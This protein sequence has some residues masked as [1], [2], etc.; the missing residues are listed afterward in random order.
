MSAGN[1]LDALDR[2]AGSGLSNREKAWLTGL[3]RRFPALS[4]RYEEDGDPALPGWLNDRRAVLAGPDAGEVAVRF[5]GFLDHLFGEQAKV[6]DEWF[7][8]S[9]PAAPDLEARKLLAIGASES[10]VLV[11]DVSGDDSMPY[12]AFRS[13]LLDASARVNSRRAFW[14]HDEM[15]SHMVAL[16]VDGEEHTAPIVDKDRIDRLA[17]VGARL[18]GADLSRARLEGL[19]LSGADLTLADLSNVSASGATFSGAI[20]TGASFEYADLDGANLSGAA[21]TRARMTKASLRGADLTGADLSGA[22][23]SPSNLDRA[24]AAGANLAGADLTASSAWEADLSGADLTGANLTDCSLP[25]ANLTGASLA[26]AVLSGASLNQARLDGVEWAGAA[27]SKVNLRA[28]SLVNADLSGADLSE[29]ELSEADL[30]GANLSNANLGGARLEGARLEGA[31]LEGAD[32]SGAEL[33]EVAAAGASFSSARLAGAKLRD[34]VL[35]GANLSGADLSGAEA[36]R[37]R[38]AE[39]DLSNANLTGLVA[40][41]SDFSR[42]IFTGAILEGCD[43]QDASFE[44]AIGLPAAESEEAEPEEPEPEPEPESE[45][46]VEAE[47]ETVAEEPPAGEAR[48]SEAPRDAWSGPIRLAGPFLQVGRFD[49][50]N[51]RHVVKVSTE[52]AEGEEEDV[53]F[54]SGADSTLLRVYAAAG[55]AARRFLEAESTPAGEPNGPARK[56]GFVRVTPY[57]FVNLA[58]AVTSL[59]EP[60]EDGDDVALRDAARGNWTRYYGDEAAGLR[61]FLEARAASGEPGSASDLP[62]M[63]SGLG[64]V[65][66]RRFLFVNLD[67]VAR[68]Y[69]GPSEDEARVVRFLAA[70]ESQLLYLAGDEAALFQEWLE[71]R[72][73]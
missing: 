67:R 31:N 5:D 56:T 64:T 28:A 51:L 29:A 36:E 48:A 35:T 3:V 66:V 10:A 60:G 16:R 45:P 53:S 58:H 71:S 73:G 55:G 39:A 21:L 33:R 46:E 9:S 59:T 12:L 50:V 14:N 69:T 47:R 72:A 32:L 13:E 42:A 2:I 8:L 11:L 22:A 57:R 18:P 37:S 30:T 41:G 20:L 1:A 25:G 43:F 49:W 19:D 54:M 17:L 52:P 34:A 6:K 26:G 61:S 40:W 27:L 7:A 70:D 65:R 4:W 62:R 63:P 38:A 15:W 68:L 23:L 44:G 24:R